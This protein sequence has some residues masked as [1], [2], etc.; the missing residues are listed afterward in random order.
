MATSAMADPGRQA[1][2]FLASLFD[3]S[4]SYFITLK[5]IRWL[6]VL[7]LVAGTVL[8][9]AAIVAAFNLHSG[10]GFLALLFSPLLFLIIAIYL[11]VTLEVVAIFF[12]LEENTARMAGKL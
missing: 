5:L 12:R 6:F 4:F 11:R 2:S 10:I 3:L 8:V 9:L 7:G 1:R